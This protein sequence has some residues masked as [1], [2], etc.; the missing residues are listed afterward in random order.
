LTIHRGRV[1]HHLEVTRTGR[2]R[3]VCRHP[4]KSFVKEKKILLTRA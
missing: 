4:C 1:T 2:S 3:P